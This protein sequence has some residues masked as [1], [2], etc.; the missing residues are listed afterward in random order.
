[1]FLAIVMVSGYVKLPSYKMYWEKTNDTI[2]IIGESMRRDRF[3]K[4]KKFLHLADNHNFNANDKF[5]KLRPI[6]SSLNDLF[7]KFSPFVECCSVDKSMVH[8]FGRHG[9][10][11]AMRFGFKVWGGATSS[12][13]IFGLTLME[14]RVATM[15]LTSTW[16]KCGKE[17]CR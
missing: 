14:A 5:S 17:M 2:P 11:Q 13:Y 3:I 12:G 1:M 15:I 7:L 16:S 8:Y 10:K 6:I 9:S 4:I